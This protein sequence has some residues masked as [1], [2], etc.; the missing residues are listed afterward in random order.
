MIQNVQSRYRRG[1]RVILLCIVQLQKLPQVLT[2]KITSTRPQLLSPNLREPPVF[3][4]QFSPEPSHCFFSPPMPTMSSP[5]PTLTL[6]QL[7][8]HLHSKSHSANSNRSQNRHLHARSS[9]SSLLHNRRTSSTIRSNTSRSSSGSRL[10]SHQARSNKTRSLRQLAVNR[11]LGLNPRSKRHNRQKADGVVGGVVAGLGIR[12]GGVE[13]LV[14]DVQ[15]A[16]L[17]QDIRVDDAGGVDEDG[18]VSGDGDF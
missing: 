4:S 10:R 2:L 8:L 14:D 11:R 17:E 13:D 7:T 1:F 16:V 9:I 12:G 3:L 18:A 6:C 5:T 15:D